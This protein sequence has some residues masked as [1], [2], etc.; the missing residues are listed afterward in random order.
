[1]YVYVHVH[2]LYA[3][4]QVD[5]YDEPDLPTPAC[6]HV[7]TSD[8]SRILY[9]G[10]FMRLSSTYQLLARS[11]PVPRTF[12]VSAASMMLSSTRVKCE[13]RCPPEGPMSMSSS[14]WLCTP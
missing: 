5:L 10:A 3:R 9:V 1:M 8:P 2:A 14:S 12:I 4:K 13:T 6:S 7:C 11:D